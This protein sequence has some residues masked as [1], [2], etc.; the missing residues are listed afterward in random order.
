MSL[1]GVPH[2]LKEVE[3]TKSAIQNIDSICFS[4]T[5]LLR[6]E[7]QRLYP[8]L[9]E[10]AE[11]YVTIIRALAKSNQGLTR[12][13]IVFNTQL[14]DNGALSSVLDELLQS[15]FIEVYRPFGKKK[16]DSLYRLTDEYS[17]FY[18]QFV[19]H[20]KQ[21]GENTWNHLSQ[22]QQ[23]KTWSGYAYEN[24]CF[25]HISQ[26]KKALGIAGVYAVSSSFFKKG[27]TT[28]K[29][30]QI[31]LLLD[32]N[33]QTI[34]LIEVKF[35]NESFSLSNHYAQALRE[36]MGVFRQATKTKKHLSW[37]LITTFGLKHNQHSLG[38][39]QNVITLD[40]LFEKG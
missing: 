18:L 9:F 22:T 14:P 20:N 39:I 2:Y 10:N 37:I 25:K 8:S 11:K 30:T 33:D 32:R 24:I 4:K 35:Y 29:G 38:L 12:S 15:G 3:G 6:D 23:Y 40:D 16:K 34:N 17:L 26:V 19:E 5:G 7:F 28:E 21:D 27:T 31:D 36:K 1:G 13:A